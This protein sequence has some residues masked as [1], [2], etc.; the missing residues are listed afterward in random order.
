[1]TTSPYALI[2]MVVGLAACETAPAAICGGGKLFGR[3]EATTGLDATQCEPRC[4]CGGGQFE[5]PLYGEAEIAALLSWHLSAPVPALLADPYASFLIPVESPEAVCAVVRDARTEPSYELA[6]FP[7]EAAARSTGA[8]PTHFG[9]CGA[10]SALADL[11]VYMR[12]PDLTTP[13]RQCGL[14]HLGGPAE[15]HLA[16]LRA[17][18]FSEPCAQIWY[19]NTIHTRDVC[20]LPCFSLIGAPY[21]EPDGA[22]NECLRCDEQQSGPVFKAIAGRTRRNTG[23]ASALCRPCSE[24]RPLLH[25]YG[26]LTAR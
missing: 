21:H 26:A 20:A 7:S 14:D 18:G 17:L 24:V 16:C 15:A 1:M 23:L 11:A 9:R 22:L 4:S 10:C 5:A 13:V 2:L 19:F 12:Y 25:D 8:I 3:P 6:S